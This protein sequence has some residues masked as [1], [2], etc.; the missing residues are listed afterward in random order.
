[1][2]PILLYTIVSLTSLIYNVVNAVCE[3]T[4]TEV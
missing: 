2:E 4:I 3:L 1:M